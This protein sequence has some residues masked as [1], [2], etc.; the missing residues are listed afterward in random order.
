MLA[1]IGLLV[2][3]Q[4]KHFLADYVLQSGWM[5]AGKADPG[6]A[7]GYVHAAIHAGATALV[8]FSFGVDWRW[9]LAIAIAEL[10]IHFT[11]DLIKARVSGD[12]L[13]DT[14]ARRFWAMHGA[15]Q[16]AHHLTYA[17]LLFVAVQFGLLGV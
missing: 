6:H 12:G 15:D 14:G 16:L 8:L 13:A 10:A 11:I 5:I 4:V 17:L 3:L 1:L 7:G 2:A 9:V